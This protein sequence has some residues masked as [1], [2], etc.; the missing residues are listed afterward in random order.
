MTDNVNMHIIKEASRSNVL[1]D[2][3]AFLCVFSII[4]VYFNRSLSY[5]T[6]LLNVQVIKQV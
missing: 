6:K 2:I 5:T 1:F 3:K 4:F